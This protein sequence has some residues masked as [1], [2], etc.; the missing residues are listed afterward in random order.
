[1]ASARARVKGKHRHSPRCAPGTL[2]NQCRLHAGELRNTVHGT[3]DAGRSRGRSHRCLTLSFPPPPA[4]PATDV[5]SLTH[6]IHSL[7][8]PPR[9]LHLDP[10]T[11]APEQPCSRA[12]CTFLPPLLTA[13]HPEGHSSSSLSANLVDCGVY[14]ASFSGTSCPASFRIRISSFAC[15]LYSIRIV[16]IR[17]ATPQ[18][19]PHKHTHTHT[20]TQVDYLFSGVK[21]ES[22]CP[23]APARPV[24]PMR[25]T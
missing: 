23:V 17:N 14:L 24:R 22:A 16:Q 21:S 9:L 4:T 5:R 2:L 25:C 3:S 1:M 7:S 8:L 15:R 13:A 18:H 11:L 19:T 20:H 12:W 10:L 6:A